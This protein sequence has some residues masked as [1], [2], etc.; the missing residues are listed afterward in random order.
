MSLL[1]NRYIDKYATLISRDGDRC[2][3]R[4]E[5]DTQIYIVPSWEFEDIEVKRPLASSVVRPLRSRPA[6][7]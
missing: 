7:M 4:Y 6:R 2:T 3:V 1:Y 5:G